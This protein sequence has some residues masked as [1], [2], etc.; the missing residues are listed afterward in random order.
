V[1]RNQRKVLNNKQQS[2]SSLKLKWINKL[3]K[4]PNKWAKSK[5]LN[6]ERLKL[7]QKRPN[8]SQRRLGVNPLK[9]ISIIRLLPS[10]VP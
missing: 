1:K 3:R 4:L 7:Q 8:K 9:K 2:R 10:Q 6:K 5:K